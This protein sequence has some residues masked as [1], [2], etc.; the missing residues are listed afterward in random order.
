MFSNKYLT[1]G[2]NWSRINFCDQTTKMTMKDIAM[3]NN[4]VQRKRRQQIHKFKK[5]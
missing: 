5:T 1:I 3:S 2:K 4:F